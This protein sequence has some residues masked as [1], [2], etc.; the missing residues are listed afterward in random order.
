[1]GYGGGRGVNPSAEV[2][3]IAVRGTDV[4]SG[5]R[6]ITEDILE[7]LEIVNER[8][9]GGRRA[10]TTCRDVVDIGEDAIGVEL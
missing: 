5:M 6:Q 7:L 10:G 3:E 4:V 2:V 8:L 1:V 9:P